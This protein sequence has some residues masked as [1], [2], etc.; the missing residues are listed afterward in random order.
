MPR[1]AERGF[2]V[3]P[4]GTR[5]ILL[6]GLGTLV[7]LRPPWHAFAAILR[8]RH[9][10]VVEPRDAER[11]FSAEIAYYRAHHVEG[12]DART[13]AEL[14]GRCAD[15]LA[16]ELPAAVSLAL[17]SAQ[18][19][20]AMLRALCF[21]TY[22]D[23]ADT[24]AGLRARGCRLV[25]VSN[26][27]ISLTA[28]LEELGLLELLDGVVTSAEVGA[29]KPAGAIFEAALARAGVE[30]A[31]AV[32]VGD[33]F[34]L[35][36]RG[37]LAAGVAAILLSRSAHPE[38]AL[39]RGAHGLSAAAG[40]DALPASAGAGELVRPVSGSTDQDALRARAVGA[41]VIASLAQLLA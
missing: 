8:E 12:R 41:P 31:G 3:A 34:A 19:A 2:P 35:D 14:R 5:A 32:H 7:A 9:G 20:A 25:V 10:L 33:S 29:P 30:P 38:D 24:L 4:A 17:S 27:D 37:A 1:G 23:V 6:D 21:E 18:L 16:R 22:P 13:L 39:A 36:V 28:V 40:D 11:A 26:W 15:V